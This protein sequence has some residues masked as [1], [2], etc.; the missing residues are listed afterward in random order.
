MCIRPLVLQ[1]RA[2]ARVNELGLTVLAFVGAVRGLRHVAP[3]AHTLV[4]LCR[5]N[6]TGALRGDPK[7]S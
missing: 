1:C 5:T 3:V 7:D 4:D 2:Q 6:G